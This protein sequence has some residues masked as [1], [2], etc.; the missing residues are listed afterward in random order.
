[1]VDSEEGGTIQCI[2]EGWNN[3]AVGPKGLDRAYISLLRVYLRLR[4]I[5]Y[6]FERRL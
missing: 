5:N 4:R 3:R 1:M 6:S 2:S